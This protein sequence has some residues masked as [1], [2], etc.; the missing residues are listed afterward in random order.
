[1]AL[2]EE[3]LVILQ[4]ILIEDEGLEQ[5]PYMDCCGKSWRMCVCK[6][7]G[8]LTVGIGRNLD[9]VGISENESLGLVINDIK[10]M[11]IQLERYFPWFSKLNTPRRIVIV[12]MA[13]NM[14]M[15]KL[16]T[17]TKMIKC[18]ESQDFASAAKEMTNS[19]WALDVKQRAIRL[20]VIMKLGQF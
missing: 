16:K 1:M 7:K 9:T 18:I 2:S 20:A 10:N 19:K 11:T 4:N 15:Q 3:E 17:F 12:C 14:G 13:F 5:F 8:F 6:D